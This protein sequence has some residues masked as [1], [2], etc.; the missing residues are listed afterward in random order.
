MHVDCVPTSIY[1]HRESN[2]VVLTSLLPVVCGVLSAGSG[3]SQALFQ[4]DPCLRIVCGDNEVFVSFTTSSGRN[5]VSERHSSLLYFLKSF[6]PVTT[7]RHINIYMA[8]VL[9]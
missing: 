3:F 6:D 1:P 2:R 5:T 9:Y 7:K 8:P 4:P